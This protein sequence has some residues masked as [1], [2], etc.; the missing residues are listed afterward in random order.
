MKFLLILLF[1]PQVVFSQN[2]ENNILL[3]NVGLG[4]ITSGIGAVINKKNENWKRCFVRGFWQGS[5]GG[6][7]NYSSKKSIYLINK[8][9]SFAYALPARLLNA[10]GNSIIQNAAANEPF[11]KNWNFEY[12][13]LRV[14]FSTGSAKKIRVR[15]LPEAVIAS[16]VA[17][18]KG[19]F[20]I[21][22]TLVTGIMS[23][24]RK[25]VMRSERG[26]HDGVNYGRAFVYQDTSEKYLIVAHEIIHE[27]QYREYLVFNSWL[28]PAVANVKA[29]GLK[30]I[31]T[32]YLYPDV[33]YFGLFYMIEGVYQYPL[34][35][36]N[37]YE[38]EAE[39]C[40]TSKFVKVQ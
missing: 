20:D 7:I 14:D 36:R 11:L 13:F 1:I 35:Y 4:G 8:N 19:K 26:I 6:L 24:K 25:E 37:Y 32:K 3:Y 30:N 22:T 5:I 38:F 23:F 29:P 15:V 18:S 12:A 33:P 10:A 39:R 31:F 27:F 17:L 34:L 16:G 2:Q 9:N 21:S 40:A 28:Q